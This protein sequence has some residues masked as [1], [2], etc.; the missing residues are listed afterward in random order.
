MDKVLDQVNDSITRRRSVFGHKLTSVFDAFAAFDTG[1]SGRL[2][3]H[4]FRAAMER[5]GLGV[6]HKV[7]TDLIHIVDDDGNGTIEYEEFVN[8]LEERSAR[9]RREGESSEERNEPV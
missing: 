4:D 3:H 9:R 1:N 8:A 7:L 5:L 6:S 2:S